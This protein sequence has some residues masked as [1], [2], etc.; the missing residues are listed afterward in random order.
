MIETDGRKN[1]QEKRDDVNKLFRHAFALA[2]NEELTTKIFYSMIFWNLNFCWKNNECFIYEFMD[3]QMNT[4]SVNDG[5][6]QC[7]MKEAILKYCLSRIYRRVIYKQVPDCT[8]KYAY[9]A[10]ASAIK[11]RNDIWKFHWLLVK[12]RCHQKR[13][14]DA[15]ALLFH[16]KK[17]AEK[18]NINIDGKI[19]LLL[20][21]KDD[22]LKT[23]LRSIKSVQN[24]WCKKRR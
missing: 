15:A 12:I 13:Y 9:K 6:E 14:A 10:A 8:F 19:I 7:R 4:A 18:Q 2:T 1:F 11:F 3:E 5:M 22:E 21:K 16:T 17:L 20:E 23:E 24:C